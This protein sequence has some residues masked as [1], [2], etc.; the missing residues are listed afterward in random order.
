MIVR[1]ISS[2]SGLR[3]HVVIDSVN[4]RASIGVCTYAIVATT[5]L[6]LSYQQQ[7]VQMS[8]AKYWVTQL[9]AS[10]VGTSEEKQLF[11]NNVTSGHAICNQE[12]YEIDAASEQREETNAC[13]ACWSHWRCADGGR[14]QCRVCG[15]G[16]RA[17][18]KQSH[19]AVG[20]DSTDNDNSIDVRRTV[21][22]TRQRAWAVHRILCSLK[23]N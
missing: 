3:C 5:T 15:A 1:V 18:D 2:S 12:R 16:I 19:W 10:T 4:Y 9:L 6:W 11:Q 8:N 20:K 7:L 21:Y 17:S 14:G 23:T 22:R 13:S